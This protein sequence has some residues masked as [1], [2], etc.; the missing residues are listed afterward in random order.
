MQLRRIIEV[1]PRVGAV[2][3]RVMAV[4]ADRHI[5][6]AEAAQACER[7]QILA[8]R[9]AVLDRGQHRQHAI[10]LRLLQRIR[11]AADTRADA[12]LATPHAVDR[13]KHVDHTIR[14]LRVARRVAATLRDVG[15]EAPGIEPARPHLEQVDMA[16]ARLEGVLIVR[17]R[18]VDV[19]VERQRRPVERL[20]VHHVWCPGQRV[21]IA[22]LR[23]RSCTEHGVPGVIRTRGPRF[24]TTSAF[25]AAPQSERSWSGLSLRP[26]SSA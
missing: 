12:V 4:M 25:T 20:G 24:H 18:N 23:R 17:P 11:G 9:V 1:A 10:A 19:A 7:R 13:L 8:D 16:A 14:R 26:G 5:D 3:Q 22:A 2:R 6:G 21:R 15:D